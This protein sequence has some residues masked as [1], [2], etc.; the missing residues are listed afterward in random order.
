MSLHAIFLTVR[1]LISR[2]V[3]RSN[4]WTLLCISSVTW[5]SMLPVLILH[6]WL[7]S[8]SVVFTATTFDW[9]SFDPFGKSS[10]ADLQMGRNGWTETFCYSFPPIANCFEISSVT[11]W[12]ESTISFSSR[13][14]KL[15]IE[16][17]MWILNIGIAQS[18]WEI[19]SFSKF[20]FLIMHFAWTIHL[21]Y[22]RQSAL[23]CR[24]LWRV[25]Q[26]KGAEGLMYGL[27]KSLFSLH[28]DCDKMIGTI[29]FEMFPYAVP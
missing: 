6:G 7:H 16:E 24:L 9:T 21:A 18:C 29:T 20:R 19:K 5:A 3:V 22:E 14:A 23:K 25:V 13:L 1:S 28:A 26:G 12:R 15:Y 27:S 11:V 8:N 10:V 2:S 17:I 4:A